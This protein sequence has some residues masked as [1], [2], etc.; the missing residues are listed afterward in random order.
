[1]G[2]KLMNLKQNWI[3]SLDSFISSRGFEKTDWGYE[4]IEI[5][6]QPGQTISFNGH[7]MQQQGKEIK[8][9][10]KIILVGDGWVA[11]SDEESNKMDFTQVKF[12]AYRDEDLALEYEEALYWDEL[13]YFT[14]IFNQIFG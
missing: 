3:Q 2:D 11:D 10:K 5:S 8:I 1:M 4:Q 7:V 6:R 13:D 14:E 12:E 9:Q